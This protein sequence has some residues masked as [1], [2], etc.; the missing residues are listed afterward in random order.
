M[1]TNSSIDSEVIKALKEGDHKSFE[2]VFLSYYNKTKAFIYGY[3]KSDADAEERMPS[4]RK[5][6]YR[7]SR[8]EG[9]TN[10]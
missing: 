6:I 3:V 4:Q 9:L 2:E 5:K 10:T 7:L 8:N 1:K